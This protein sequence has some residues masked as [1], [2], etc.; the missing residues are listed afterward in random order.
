MLI[1]TQVDEYKY[2]WKQFVNDI[3]EFKQLK[4]INLNNCPAYVI[5]DSIKYLPQLEVLKAT[6]VK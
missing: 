1:P 6:S 3:K 5:E 2:F 4:V